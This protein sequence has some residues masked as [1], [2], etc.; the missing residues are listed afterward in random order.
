MI[1][2]STY[3]RDIREPCFSQPLT[4][5]GDFQRK[6]LFVPHIRA[7]KWRSHELVAAGADQTLHCTHTHTHM[8]RYLYITVFVSPCTWM[9]VFYMRSLLLWTTLWPWASKAPYFTQLDII[10]PA[11]CYIFTISK[12]VSDKRWRFW[13]DN[14]ERFYKIDIAILVTIF[15]VDSRH[16]I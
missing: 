15:V 9:Y 8:Y 5:K 16:Q 4:R 14:F 12:S 7:F 3:T 13:W 2:P 10:Y 6:I 11:F 1:R